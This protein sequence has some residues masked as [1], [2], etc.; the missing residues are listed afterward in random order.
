MP[1]QLRGRRAEA[2]AG[3][4]GAGGLRGGPEDQPRQRAGAAPAGA[5]GTGI[6]PHPPLPSPGPAVPS[7]HS[8]LLSRSCWRSRAGT[9]RR[10]WSSGEPWSWTRPTRCVRRAARAGRHRDLV[11]G[12][13]GREGM[14][15]ESALGWSVSQ[16]SRPSPAGDP[17][18]A[19]TAGEAPELPVQ[20]P[21]EPPPG[22][23][24]AAEPC[25]RRRIGLGREGRPSRTPRR[26]W[27]LEPS[28]P[29][30]P[31]RR[32]RRRKQSERP[33]SA[34]E[35]D[36]GDR[37]ALTPPAPKSHPQK[38]RGG[39]ELCGEG[40]ELDGAPPLPTTPPSSHAPRAPAY[41]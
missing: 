7:R 4:G 27:R 28:F 32:P 2:G 9:G 26:G 13:M 22:P 23:A 8:P 17:H 35:P 36:G 12:A 40:E 24:A 11:P 25:V 3:G 1:Q 6:P 20:H 39:G 5:G 34:P 38:S 29:A 33:R 31:P 41:P 10:R 15:Q 30:E 14:P 16:R 21:A 37:G 19:L 18:R